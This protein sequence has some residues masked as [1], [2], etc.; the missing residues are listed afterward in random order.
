MNEQHQ[1][2]SEIKDEGLTTEIIKRAENVIFSKSSREKVEKVTSVKESSPLLSSVVVKKDEK[3]VPTESRSI[4]VKNVSQVVKVSKNE[5]VKASIK[6]RL[7]R[8]I[9]ERSRSRSRDRGDRN[10][11]NDSKLRKHD[12]RK[13]LNS[14]ISSAPSKASS[15][16]RVRESRVERRSRSRD[17][18]KESAKRH[19]RSKSRSPDVHKDRNNKSKISHHETSSKKEQRSKRRS[20]SPRSDDGN[21]RKKMRS[22]SVDSKKHKKKKKKEKKAKKKSRDRK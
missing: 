10:K 2:E 8:K 17:N 16:I 12:N 22:S 14:Y 20:D 19:Q 11:S 7:G 1:S 13:H 3:N 9:T 5:P 15:G 21:E 18:R 4:E 6:E